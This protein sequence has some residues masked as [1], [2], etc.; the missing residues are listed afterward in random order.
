MNRLDDVIALSPN[1]VVENLFE[2][3]SHYMQTVFPTICVCRPFPII[4]RPCSLV[5]LDLHTSS[6][7]GPMS[8]TARQRLCSLPWHGRQCILMRYSIRLNHG[9]SVVL[10][11]GTTHHSRVDVLSLSGAGR[12]WDKTETGCGLAP[13]MTPLPRSPPHRYPSTMNSSHC[14]HV[15]PEDLPW[16]A[17]P[18]CPTALANGSV[19]LVARL[20]VVPQTKDFSTCICDVSFPLQREA[21]CFSGKGGFGA[22]VLGSP[23][24]ARFD[25]PSGRC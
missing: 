1:V 23:V 5:L 18:A 11:F 17:L 10:M 4:C 20:G 19:G 7:I 15:Q 25:G 9:M 6:Q 8:L 14:R 21:N 13:D 22:S 16:D 3:K 24:S 2:I 12:K